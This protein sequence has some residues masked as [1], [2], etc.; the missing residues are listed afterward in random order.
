MEKISIPVLISRLLD[1]GDDSSIKLL[2]DRFYPQSDSQRVFSEDV[3]VS[4]AEILAHLPHLKI[5]EIREA[6]YAGIIYRDLRCALVH[7]YKVSSYLTTFDL[8]DERENPSYVNMRLPPNE[9]EAQRLAS[10]FGIPV[11]Y[12]QE[13]ISNQTRLLYLPY[14]FIRNALAS[15]ANSAFDV[16]DQSTT[17]TKLPHRYWW[18]ENYGIGE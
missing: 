2:M 5:P 15:V 10:E 18:I 4:E 8:W 12:A 3:D 9:S 6:S 14:P 7:E 1:R 11:E 16:W 13:A 17:F